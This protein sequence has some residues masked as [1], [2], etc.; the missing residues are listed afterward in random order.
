MRSLQAA[1]V[2]QSASSDRGVARTELTA[3]HRLK[4]DRNVPCSNCIARQTT[5]VFSPQARNRI[6]SSRTEARQQF[7]SRIRRL[8][9]LVNSMVSQNSRSNASE[10]INSKESIKKS[11]TASPNGPESEAEI[12]SGRIVSSNDQTIYVS[13]AHWASICYEVS[14]TG[15]YSKAF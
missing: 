2:S 14:K 9:Q 5:C 10:S 7:D 12:E 1:E 6:S 13:G 11:S 4:C 8:E 15:L 3:C